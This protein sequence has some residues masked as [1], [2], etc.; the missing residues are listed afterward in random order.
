[1]VERLV[2]DIADGRLRLGVFTSLQDLVSAIDQYIVHL[3]PNPN[4][5]PK[6]FIGT[7]SARDT[8]QKIIRTDGYL[9]SKQNVKQH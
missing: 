3:N 5:N 4:P 7:K 2:R 6:Q 1:M 8:L 9:G